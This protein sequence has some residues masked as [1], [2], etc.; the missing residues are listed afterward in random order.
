MRYKGTSASCYKFANH[1]KCVNKSQTHFKGYRYYNNG[2]II[3]LLT[4]V[5]IAV[6]VVGYLP[7][8]GEPEA[9]EIVMLPERVSRGQYLANHVT[10]LY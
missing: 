2:L 5:S 1:G 3:L 6:Y 9:I 7:N 10:E 4:I 8:V